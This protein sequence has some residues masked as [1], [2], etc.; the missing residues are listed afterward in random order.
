MRGANPGDVWIFSHVHYCNEN[1]QKHPTQKPEGLIERMILSSSDKGDMVVDPFAGSGTTLRVCQQTG[2]KCIGI[3]LNKDYVSMIKER[4]SKPF[5]A[6]DSIDPRMER[7]PNDLN[8]PKTRKE[9]LDKHVKWFL[10][11]HNCSIEAFKKEVEKRY[12]NSSKKEQWQETFD[13]F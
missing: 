5:E 11:H 7:V 12:G 2:R 3:E 8:N 10:K 13:F 6:F 4:L 9:Y 1:R